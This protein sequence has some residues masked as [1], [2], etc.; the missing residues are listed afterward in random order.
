MQ[1]APIVLF[2]YNRPDHTRR[3]LDSLKANLLADQ[4][5]LYIFCDGPK[6][7]TSQADIER[8][9][10]VRA[11]I[12]EEN[13][14]RKIYI[15]EA[16]TNKGLA[17][18]IIDGVTEVVEQQG[19]VIVLEDDLELSPGFLKYM[20]DALE[21]YNDEERVMHISGFMFPVKTELP[22]TF[23]YK[24]T[25]CSGG[26]ATWSRAW[27]HLNSDPLSLYKKLLDT[28]QLHRFNLEGSSDQAL[29][30]YSNIDGNL[31]TWAIKWYA[32][33]FLQNG[34]CLHPCKSLTRNIGFDELSSNTKTGTELLDIKEV[35][36]AINVYKI[37]LEES[38][39]AREAY[40]AMFMDSRGSK[41]KQFLYKNY[42]SSILIR[43]FF[44]YFIKINK[45]F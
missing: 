6:E 27:K 45:L 10:A 8:I 38:E 43:L 39:T 40:K 36:E 21:F 24:F 16:E 20:N 35:S 29:Q 30:L 22:E 2:T 9:K 1:L 23:F 7:G 5:E 12:R 42:S 4:S 44:R 15:K 41:I 32:T 14:T 11:L 33:V 26:W 17:R 31:N 18:S 19:R 28:D 34:L 25:T 13:W 3:T 37:D